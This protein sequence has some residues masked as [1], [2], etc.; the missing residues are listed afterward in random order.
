MGEVYDLERILGRINTGL[1]NPRDT[2]ALGKSLGILARVEATLSKSNDPLL[3]QARDTV[4]TLRADLLTLS[5]RILNTQREDAPLSSRDGGVFKIGTHTELDRLININEDGQKWLIDLETREREAT[6]ISSLKVRYNRVFGY[7][8]EITQSHLKNAPSHYQRKQTTVGAER[9]FTEELKKFEDE[10]VNAVSRQKSL[11]QD[12]FGELLAAIQ[13]KTQVI[14][15]AARVYGELDSLV[16]LAKLTL[17]HGWVFPEIDSSLTLEITQGRHPLVDAA[18]H[19]QFVPNDLSLS[20]ETRLT[21]MI[22]GPN[23]GGKSTIMRQTAL[24][25]LLGQMGAPVPALAARWGSV[26]SLYTR[27]G[28]HDAIARGQSTFMVEMSELAHI[29]HHADEN[30]LIVLDEIGRGTST[31]DGISVAWATLE[32]I[33]SQLRARTLFATH[34][35]E[36]TRLSQSI[37][38]LA[39]AHMAVE[40][41][42]NNSNAEFRFLYLLKDGPANESFGI[43]VARLAGIPKSVVSRAWKVL[44]ELEQTNS[45]S[46]NVQ[47]SNQLSLFAMAP[48]R[49]EP[50]IEFE[51]HP[52]LTQIGQLDTNQMTPL[53]ALN[54]LARLQGMSR[55]SDSKSS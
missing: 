47:D 51:P 16:S 15:E 22:T 27:I 34:Y 5:E 18:S 33:C 26:S 41:Q 45:L 35:H 29:L 10:I 25:V 8:I 1:A 4:R 2:F 54:W 20:A 46:V 23:M 36:L 12:L 6:G 52:V 9:F 53:E 21:L 28:S 31:Y 38:G 3:A 7:Y 48:A 11:E 24:I 43:H 30:S 13:Q 17:D 55:E 50:K 37:P 42:G 44:E 14:M 39:N 40:S 49:E 32:Y 19:G